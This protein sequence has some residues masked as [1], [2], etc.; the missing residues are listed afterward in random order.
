MLGQLT[1]RRQTVVASE[2]AAKIEQLPLREGSS[3]A[4][5]QLLIAFNDTLQQA[6]LKR[7]AAS[8][9]AAARTAV[10]NEKLRALNSIGQVEYELSVAE[11]AKASA[12]LAY[13]EAML[14][15]CRILAPYAGRV[16]ELRVR[17]KEFA[18][19]GQALFEIIDADL[20]EIEFIV[21]SHTLA[22]LAIGQPV[23][24]RIEET[25]LEHPARIDRIGARVE[26]VSRTIKVV[27][28]FTGN[29]EGLVAGMSGSITLAAPLAP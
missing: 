14:S 10:A 1:P 23:T 18:Q 20:P 7:A 4:E 11:L 6:Q 29:P 13:A 27:A 15:K 5:G 16:A 2:I 17:E 8:H 22:W 28:T 25:G 9:T 21:P 26:P 24:V 19:V 12:E 3:F